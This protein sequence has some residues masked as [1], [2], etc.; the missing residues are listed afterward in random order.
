MVHR[1]GGGRMKGKTEKRGFIKAVFYAVK[2]IMK[3]SPGFIT[4]QLFSMISSWF[5]TG[6]VQE[7]LFL[8]MVLKIIEGG[9][10]Y[11]DFVFTVIMFAA[12]GILSKFGNNFFDW[13]WNMKSKKFYKNLNKM[14]FAKAREVDIECYENPEFFDYYKRAT[15]ILTE[16]HY[17]DF[18]TSY[19]S[20]FADALTG[21][22][23]A[24]YV[25]SIDPKLLLVLLLILPMLILQAYKGRLDVKKDKDMTF[26]KRTKAYVKRIIYLKDFSK[27]MRTSDILAVLHKR[28]KDAVKNNRK[29]IKKYGCKAAL[30]ETFTGLFGRALPVVIAYIYATFRYAVK[31]N[32]RLA[33]FSVIMTAMDNIKSIVNDMG[34]AINTTRKEA[35]YFENLRVFLEYESKVVSGSKEAEELETLEFRNVT[36]TYPGAEKPTLKNINVVFRKGETTAIVGHNGAGKTTFVKLLLRFYDPQEGVILYNGIDLKEYDITSLRN[37]FATVF[38]DYKV[39]ALS[40]AEN[41]L[42]KEVQNEDESFKVKE[43]LKNSGAELFVKRLPEKENTVITREFDEKGT[44]LSGGEQQKVAVARMFAKDYDFAVLDEP[45]SALDPVAE[46]KMYET[47]IEATKNKTVVYISHRLSSAVLSDKIYVFGNGTVQESGTH[48][49][50][51]EKHGIYAEMFNL[52]ASSYKESEGSVDE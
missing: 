13:I 47:L 11:R 15:E 35:L 46:Y 1:E 44:G 37:R 7:I 6:F 3:C 33:D 43:A 12:A 49:S 19:S 52:Q 21:I 4:V 5:F 14:I 20:I 26:H 29:I 23:I 18:A 32:L 51:M 50:L 16:N 24:A 2:I 10:T 9:G 48:E 8:R 31:K 27:D 40:V 38:Q 34:S 39:F 22:F 25:I 17:L 45:S 42:C 30:L 41:V 36:F 28:Y